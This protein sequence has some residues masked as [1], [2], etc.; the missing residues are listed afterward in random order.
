MEVVIQSRY[1]LSTSN[2]TKTFSSMVSKV[3][4]RMGA[5]LRHHN[6][7]SPSGC[8]NEVGACEG[9]VQDNGRVVH[10]CRRVPPRRWLA[11]VQTQASF[12]I[13]SAKRRYRLGQTMRAMSGVNG[14]LE[15]NFGR[16]S[17]FLAD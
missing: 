17:G 1:T 11:N 12:K 10:R 5:L 14:D 16:G 7:W 3:E 9:Q 8:I 4:V 2:F 6:G 15:I 13:G